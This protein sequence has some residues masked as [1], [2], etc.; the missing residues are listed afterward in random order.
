MTLADSEIAPFRFHRP[1]PKPSILYPDSDGKP[2]AEN[3]LQFEYLVLLK[4]GFEDLF[5]DREDVFVAGD[6]LWYPVEGQ[7]SICAAPDVLVALGRPKGYRGSYKQ[8]EEGG[9][10][11]SF[12][13]EVLSP[14]NR[15]GEM[16]RKASFYLTHGAKE[17]L[18]YDP[19]NGSLD[20]LLRREQTLPDGS[21]ELDWESVTAPSGWTSPSTGVTFFLE[22]KD[23]VPVRPDHQRFESYAQARKRAAR[24]SERADEEAARAQAAEA[25]VAELLAKLKAAG[26]EE[27]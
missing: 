13:A 23:L 3:P 27:A 22:G 6:L 8:W 15:P 19:D 21:L 16:A 12:V 10:A 25:R 2:T 9:V 1:L 14:N 5:E 26:L 7:P 20:V 4:Q 11:P 17:Y 18:I 24:E